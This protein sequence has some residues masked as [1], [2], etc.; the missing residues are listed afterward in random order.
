MYCLHA[1]YHLQCAPPDESHGYGEPPSQQHLSVHVFS[2]ESLIVW[3]ILAHS[4]HHPFV[5]RRLTCYILSTLM[6]SCLFAC[7]SPLL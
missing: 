4:D 6:F 5:H 2:V 7:I 3:L 1:T